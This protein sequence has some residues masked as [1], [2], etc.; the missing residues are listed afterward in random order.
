M[1]IFT[2]KNFERFIE[3]QEMIEEKAEEL[4]KEIESI[5]P[6]ENHSYLTFHKIEYGLIEYQGS[7]CGEDTTY[8]LPL[9]LLYDE[10]FKAE[11]FKK[12]EYEA[13]EKRMLKKEKENRI[14]KEKLKKEK[15]QYLKLK[16][17]FENS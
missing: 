6:I 2:E 9:S 10:D 1:N 8:S 15:E 4:I 17:K 13:I 14:K 11:Y 16:A 7:Y 5:S 3:F 12:L